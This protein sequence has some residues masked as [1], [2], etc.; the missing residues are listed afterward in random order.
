MSS[1]K[2]VFL[3]PNV[4]NLAR[5]LHH[6]LWRRTPHVVGFLDVYHQHGIVVLEPLSKDLFQMSVS[7]LMSTYYSRCLENVERVQQ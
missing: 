1:Q 2:P 3:G 7:H 4:A 6:H 5:A